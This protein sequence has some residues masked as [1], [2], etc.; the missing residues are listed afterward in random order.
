MQTVDVPRE[1]TTAAA[2]VSGADRSGPA[3]ASEV[4]G[5]VTAWC[6]LVLVDMTLR[7]AGFNRFYRL[8]QAIRTRGTASVQRRQ[9]RIRNATASVDRARLYYFKHAWC[10]QSAAAAACYLRLHGVPADVVIGV[11]KLPFMAHAWVEVNGDV[12]MNELPDLQAAFREIA[13]C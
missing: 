11:R 8:M 4:A 1:A 2:A 13:R 9:E 5:T 3:A 10:L 7:I 6:L 12:V